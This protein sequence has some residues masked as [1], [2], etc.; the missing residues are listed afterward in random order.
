MS[1]DTGR[2]KFGIIGFPENKWWV[3]ITNAMTQNVEQR[4]QFASHFFEW[5]R[6][7]LNLWT[8]RYQ[9]ACMAGWY[10]TK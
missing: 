8:F 6:K 2:S 10:Y 5:T 4:Y 1:N 3:G 9:V 7:D